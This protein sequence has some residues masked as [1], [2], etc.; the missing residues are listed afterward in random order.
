MHMSDLLNAEL[1]IVRERLGKADLRILET[2]CIRNDSERYRINDGWSTLT[3]AEHVHQFGGTHVSI[4]LDIAAA[5]RVLKRFNLENG[6]IALLPGY[7][8]DVMTHLLVQEGPY[9]KDVIL[10]DSDNDP[11]LILHEFFIAQ[12]MLTPGGVILIDDVGLDDSSTDGT[13]GRAV[14]PWA[15]KHG[16]K[17]R[18]ETRHGDGYVTNVVVMPL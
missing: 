2:G 3:F 14:L 7:S 1:A 18:M 4:D 12:R 13:K 5:Q 6:D 17:Y 16:L 9:S 11:N 10:L 15:H 8:I